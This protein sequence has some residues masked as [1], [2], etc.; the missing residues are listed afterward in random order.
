MRAARSPAPTGASIRG[1]AID[2]VELDPTV[3]AAG[4]RFLGLG[5]NPRP[6]GDHRRRPTVPR[7]HR[8]RYDLIVVDAYRQPYIPVLPR[9]EG[10]LRARAAAPDAGRHR[11]AQRRRD[12]GRQAATAA[13]A[14]SLAAAGFPQ[15]W[16]WPALRFN[17]LLLGLD[18]PSTR[19]QLLRR[20]NRVAPPLRPLLPLLRRELAPRRRRTSHSPTTARRSEWLTDRMI[21]TAIA[22]GEGL[23]ERALPTAP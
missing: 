8:R 19:E 5:D 23:D 7:A 6:A 14:A 16:V 17:D 21:F 3:T 18:R 11:R 15:A 22:R 9:D 13:L 4:R 1:V 2:G 20:A 10:V 12:A